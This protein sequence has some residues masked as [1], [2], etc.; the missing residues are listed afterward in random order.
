MQNGISSTGICETGKF[1]SIYLHFYS[2]LLI[3]LS[4]M[5]TSDTGCNILLEQ[6]AA[7]LNDAS[8]QMLLIKAQD[9]NILLC[10]EYAVR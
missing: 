9:K 4:D 7:A 6:T 8:L 5:D 2:I 10:I 1:V 3:I